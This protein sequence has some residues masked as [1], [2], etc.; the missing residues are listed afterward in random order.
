MEK[1]SSSSK[2]KKLPSPEIISQSHLSDIFQM[3]Y[4]DLLSKILNIS[5]ETFMNYLSQQVKFN[6][7]IINKFFTSNLLLSIAE[8]FR[9]KYIKDFEIINKNLDEL[10]KQSLSNNS[11]FSFLSK[12]NCY[13]HCNN[14]SEIKHKCGN[15]LIYHTDNFIYCLKCNKVYNKNQ[16]KLFCK[17]CN[18]KYYTTIKKISCKKFENLYLVK[19]KKYH[20]PKN[21]EIN[22]QCLRCNSNL[23]FNIKGKNN[24]YSDSNEIKI[25]ICPK[26]K[27]T[28]NLENI[29]FKCKD[30]GKNFKCQA[31]LIRNFSHNKKKILFLVHALRKNKKALP[32]I[33]LC[34]KN[35][36]CDISNINLFYHQ[37]KGVLIEARKNK[38]I[39]IIC[40]KCFNLFDYDNINWICPVCKKN[41]KYITD[42]MQKNQI[43]INDDNKDKKELNISFIHE[44]KSHRNI[45]Y[46]KKIKNNNNSNKQNKNKSQKFQNIIDNIYEIYDDNNKQD[47][48]KGQKNKL[49]SNVN[50]KNF[51]IKN[52]QQKVNRSISNVQN[53]NHSNNLYYCEFYYK[54]REKSNYFPEIITN[55]DENKNNDYIHISE[56][57]KININKKF[58]KIPNSN[59]KLKIPTS[60][61]SFL[62]KITKKN[63]KIL[64]NII[65]NDINNVILNNENQ[66]MPVNT[67]QNQYCYK[68]KKNIFGKYTNNLRKKN[69][70]NKNFF[71]KSHYKNT[72]QGNNI[73]GKF[74]EYDYTSN[75]PI[76]ELF[77]KNNLTDYKNNSYTFN[78]NIN[79]DYY[80]I[81]KILG[82]GTHGC[83]YL[84]KDPNTNE[85]FALKKIFIVDQYDLRKNEDEISLILKFLNKYPNINIVNIYGKQIKNIDQYNISLNILMEAALY[86]WETELINRCKHKI[87]YTERE[88]IFILSSLVETLSILQKN[89]IYHRDIKPKN[90]LFFGNNL[91]KLSDF[92]EAIYINNMR[93]TETNNQTIRGTELYMSPL[94]FNAIKLFPNSLIEYNAAK[95]DVFSLG[96]CFLYASSLEYDC[97]FRVRG[98]YDMINMNEM[99][100]SYLGKIYSQE[101]INLIVKMLQLEEKFRPDFI[102]LNSLLINNNTY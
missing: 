75:N 34:N 19:Y 64:T 2:N 51:I 100:N 44:N 55:E 11:K 9:Q 31:K 54:N 93:Y 66:L 80:K 74:Y 82:K 85:I 15:K 36:L 32:D 68:K 5:Q 91:Y 86:D 99:V 35:C 63:E 7:Q 8:I 41:F 28:F 53:N 14:C 27:L 78:D 20:C 40:N 46:K 12:K 70:I 90:I 101:Y 37:D 60:K 24:T 67:L 26:C 13:I 3:H 94:L 89:G 52:L 71:Y 87:Y 30:C 61:K 10:K 98:I 50:K 6:L 62:K 84:I 58:R 23:F 48:I 72:S 39:K 29:F 76:N 92:G 18:K 95:S 77:Y 59:S 73:Y 16:L 65:T 56:V 102:E 43:K 25:I 45:K 88:L 38:Q 42:I 79:S 49:N 17:E 33:S 97:L 1:S 96:L 22:I 47:G 21:E 57:G 81:I 69:N 83:T 4:D